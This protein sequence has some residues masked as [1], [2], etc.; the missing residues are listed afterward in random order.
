M[1]KV[2]AAGIFCLILTVVNGSLF[3]VPS[4]TYEVDGVQV[5]QCVIGEWYDGNVYTFNIGE[6]R[7]LPPA[8]G[9]GSRFDCGPCT[10]D[11]M[12]CAQLFEESMVPGEEYI[13]K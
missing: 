6:R 12:G 7:I 13:G 1:M 9:T 11:D 8:G 3:W 10:A 5:T 4:E 2:A